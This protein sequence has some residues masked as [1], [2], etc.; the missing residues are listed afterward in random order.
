M[1]VTAALWLFALGIV[2]LSIEG[3]EVALVFFGISMWLL[4]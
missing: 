2:A 3:L 1:L 4:A